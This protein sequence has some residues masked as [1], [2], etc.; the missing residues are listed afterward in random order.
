MSNNI[1]NSNLSRYSDRVISIKNSDYNQSKKNTQNYF[2]QQKKMIDISP[3]LLGYKIGEK[4]SGKVQKKISRNKYIIKVNSEIFKLTSNLSL[5]IGSNLNFEIV[6]ILKNFISADIKYLNSEKLFSSKK[7]KLDF[8][9]KVSTASTSYNLGLDYNNKST[10]LLYFLNLISLHEKNIFNQY[11]VKKLPSFNLNDSKKIIDLL[12]NIFNSNIQKWL[13][14]DVIKVLKENK[15]L[16]IQDEIHKINSIEKNYNSFSLS[17]PFFQSSNI[18]IFHFFF[19]LTNER[20][21]RFRFKISF[22]LSHGE[23]IIVEGMVGLK[24]IS[25]N[26]FSLNKFSIDLENKIKETFYQSIKNYFYFGS[27]NFKK[28]IIDPGPVNAYKNNKLNLNHKIEI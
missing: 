23:E 15:K 3:A 6:S 2:N 18:T 8:I 28:L 22:E 9:Q 10:Y 1:I 17:I 21:K 4:Y 12:S 13:G 7:I 19:I 14:T 24:K 20:I 11:I 25:I 26:I 16:N 5:D 27:I